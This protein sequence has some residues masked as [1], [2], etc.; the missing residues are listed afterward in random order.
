MRT[1][2]IG[3]VGQE[4]SDMI[5]QKDPVD[6]DIGIVG[7]DGEIVGVVIPKDAYG[8]FLRKVEEEEDRQD[9]ITVD[10]FHK[11]GEKDQ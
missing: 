2:D 3:N 4:L 11:S 7:S 5:N 6:E 9:Q 10:E 1:I 8:F